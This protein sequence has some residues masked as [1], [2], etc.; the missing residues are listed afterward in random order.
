MPRCLVI[1]VGLLLIALTTTSD[2][3]ADEAAA[4][5]RARL[6][7]EVTLLT[8]D[9]LSQ[10]LQDHMPTSK[11]PDDT[12]VEVLLSEAV[13][14]RG[15]Y[16]K[17]FLA[18]LCEELNSRKLEDD[19]FG[20]QESA[21][22]LNQHFM[23]ALRRVQ[24]LQDPLKIIILESDDLVVRPTEWPQIEV[25]IS[26]VDPQGLPV[27]F[28]FGGDNRSGRQDRW[29]VHA[30]DEQGRVFP[31]RERFAMHGGGLFHTGVL[32]AGQTWT[33]TLNLHSFL[34]PLPPGQYRLQVLYH[35]SERLAD[36]TAS[37][38]LTGLMIVKSDLVELRS[39][40]LEVNVTE[41]EMAQARAWISQVKARPPIKIVAGTYGEWAHRYV[42]PASPEGMLLQ[43][44][45]KALPAL[46]EAIENRDVSSTQKAVLFALLFSITGENDPR[47]I[48]VLPSY[49]YFE[50]PWQLWGSGGGT[51]GFRSVGSSQSTIDEKAQKALTLTWLQRLEAVKVTIQK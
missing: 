18:R 35:D 31:T 48:P 25:G 34:T 21:E 33:T 6:V 17:R 22:Q 50:A 12:D 32:K 43:Q 45:T 27:G 11:Y 24:G 28:T 16:W 13:R 49:T 5:R 7:H 30:I 20:T 1:K 40:P 51:M 37:S 2:L 44:K 10:R 9:D 19:V 41:L 14:R 38:E 15:P 4:A 29:R 36:I 39:E 47:T 3:L 46:R 8:D 42:A 23:L 26:N